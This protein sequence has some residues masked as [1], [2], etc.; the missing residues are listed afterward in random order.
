VQK[1]HLVGFTTDH[2]G[3]IFS[4]RRGAKSGGYVVHVDEPL[5]LAFEELRELLAEEQAAEA[6][7]AAPSKQTE[8]SL[9]VREVQA[10]LRRGRTI[11]QVAREAGV[12]AAWVAR[13]AVPIL[14][15][16]AEV[17][18]AARTTRMTKQRIGLS[19]ATLG[20]AVYRNLAERGVTDPR[21]EL[22]RGW[23]AHQLTDGVWLVSI[24]YTMGGVEREAVWEYDEREG[25]LRSR[26]RL[27]TQLGFREP[28]R[29]AAGAAKAEP[30]PKP[31]S[32]RT[33]SSRT[34]TARTS[35]SRQAAKKVGAARRAAAARMVSDAEKATRRNAAVAR[36]A[37]TK[38]VVIPP[39]RIVSPPPMPPPRREPLLV[40]EP[41]ETPR[42]WREE[43]HLGWNEVS[44]DE[45]DYEVDADLDYEA[46]EEVEYE[47]EEE[48]EDE[49]DHEPQ[50]P[51][52]RRREP[53][54]ARSDP[55]PPEP[56]PRVRIRF[57][58]GSDA[59]EHNNGP[60]FRSDLRSAADLDTYG[61]VDEQMPV[62]PLGAP[63]P[64]VEPVRRRRRQLRAR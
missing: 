26:G 36:K 2:R 10:R 61:L 45:V 50:A 1:L 54:R 23:R 9:S 15:E 58:D 27:G 37:A 44:V 52:P 6:E 53:L 24:T 49:V 40:D 33:S 19:S 30:K 18:R 11:D 21:D 64:P 42:G 55:A 56:G 35:S 62:E 51:S 4:V 22:D 60:I 31:S 5:L 25:S 20:E 41:L 32:A 7:A 14:A 8:S 34:S 47:A 46:E 3:L 16:Q 39:R 12:D 38:P 57:T 29:R 59:A 48:V 63:T 43:L 13:F 17:I 28:A